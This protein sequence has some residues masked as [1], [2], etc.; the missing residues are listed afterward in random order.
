MGTYTFNC[1]AVR[2]GSSLHA[3]RRDIFLTFHLELQSVDGEKSEARSSMR[4]TLR[5]QRG[6]SA[7]VVDIVVRNHATLSTTHYLLLCVYWRLTRSVWSMFL[8]PD[9][10]R[11]L[12]LRIYHLLWSPSLH[13]IFCYPNFWV[14]SLPFY[15]L[16]QGDTFDTL[17]LLWL[18][19]Q[20]KGFLSLA[21]QIKK[22]TYI[23]LIGY[24]LINF[25]MGTKRPHKVQRKVTY[26][27][28]QRL[29]PWI[30]RRKIKISN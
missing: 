15:L 12:L 4:Y 25:P 1:S 28:V 16:F 11:T 23:I 14:L 10:G 20:W 7:S 22:K 24:D 13:S 19:G 3:Q 18:V 6:V 29:N 26:V 21:D 5:C 9:R 27:S 30:R 2:G 8:I 17:W